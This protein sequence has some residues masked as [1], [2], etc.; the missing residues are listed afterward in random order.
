[1]ALC[2]ACAHLH[3]Q[4]ADVA[5]ARPWQVHHGWSPRALSEGKWKATVKP[6]LD[7]GQ[8]VGTVQVCIYAELFLENHGFWNMTGL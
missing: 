7:R 3:H 8:N 6:D 4:A 2:S 5:P 1:M